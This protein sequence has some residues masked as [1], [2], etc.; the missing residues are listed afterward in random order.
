MRL[1]R[2]AARLVGLG[3]ASVGLGTILVAGVNPAIHNNRRTVEGIRQLKERDT[4]LSLMLM[5]VRHSLLASYDPIVEATAAIDLQ[6]AAVLEGPAAFGTSGKAIDVARR[7]AAA[8]IR[9]KLRAVED[10]K[11]SFAILRNTVATLSVS[12]ADLGEIRPQDEAERE[13]HRRATVLLLALSRLLVDSGSQQVRAVEHARV[14][15]A[16]S[17]PVTGPLGVVLERISAQAGLAQQDRIRS[18]AGIAEVMNLPVGARLD[19][20]IAAYVRRV[21]R[22]A[23][24]RWG[25]E[26]A[27]GIAALL[28]AIMGIQGLRRQRLMRLSLEGRVEARTRDLAE[29]N[30]TLTRSSRAKTDFLANMSHEIRTPLAAILGFADLLEDQRLKF[31]E[32]HEIARVI[33]RNGEHLL[34]ILSDI[35]EITKIEAG[36]LKVEAIACS[37]RQ[38]AGEVCALMRNRAQVKGLDMSLRIVPPNLPGQIE[39][40]PTRLRQI[41]MNLVGN[42]IKFTEKGSVTIE[43]SAPPRSSL[44][45]RFDVEDTGIGMTDEEMTRIFAEFEQADSSTTRRFGGTGLGLAICRRLTAVLGGELTVRSA[46]GKGSTFTLLLPVIALPDSAD[47]NTTVV[48]APIGIP[49]RTGLRVLVADDS[50]DILLLVTRFLADI[51]AEVAVVSNGRE[52]L[53]MGLTAAREGRPFDVIL[54]DLHMPE[55]DG[56]EAVEALRRAGLTIPIIALTASVYLEDRERCAR[57]G[58]TDFLT[59]P[60]DRAQLI[61]KIATLSGIGEGPMQPEAVPSLA[62][63]EA[64]ERVPSA[65]P[66]FNAEQLLIMLGGDRSMRDSIL[67]MFQ[68]DAPAL[69]QSIQS[70]ASAADIAAVRAMSHKL[71]GM[72]LTVGAV[73]AAASATDLEQSA[74]ASESDRFAPLVRALELDLGRVYDSMV[75]T[76]SAGS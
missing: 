55:L 20:L 37:P 1:P 26:V 52:A 50:A 19:D 14:A 56:A 76:A 44:W 73:Q 34:A 68:K 64:P 66:V 21:D 54:M 39:S 35:L 51:D 46:P 7:V 5:R 72:L 9:S 32:R 24:Y 30:A 28:S 16:A 57:A 4:G 12:A 18:E 48:I 74:R 67:D 6:S 65:L 10:F 59:K 27:L 45:L 31:T 43:V 38:I 63:A 33:R 22:I 61:Q 40:D 70:A 60:L 69:L 36:K 47:L 17:P 41:L 25:L 71:K 58:Y 8:T 11:S 23:F 15:L 29:A 13:A 49:P 3:I 62:V 42:A 75:R 2:R 53:E